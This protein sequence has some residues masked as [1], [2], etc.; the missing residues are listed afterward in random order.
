MGTGSRG[1]GGE[2][3]PREQTGPGEGP[4]GP[5]EGPRPREQAGPGEGPRPGERPRAQPRTQAKGAKEGKGAKGTKGAVRE[6]A[7]VKRSV[8]ERAVV[9]L[10]GGPEGQLLVR[11]A[12]RILAG[13]EGAELHAVHVRTSR[14][15]GGSPAELDRQRAL[16]DRLGG[17]YHSVG[18]TDIAAALADFARGIN[19]TQVVVGVPAHGRLPQLRRGVGARL[20]RLAPG[21]DVH[22]V[23]HGQG[24]ATVAVPRPRSPLG[25]GR[26]IAG[27]VLA[28]LLPVLLQFLL[29]LFEHGHFATDMLVQ[30]SGTIAV[31]LVGGLWPAVLAAVLSSAVVNLSAVHPVGTLGISDPENVLA[32]LIFLAVAIAVSLVVGLSA[33]RSREAD[34]AGAEAAALGELSRSTLAQHYTV[35][36]FMERIREYFQCQGAGLYVL[37]A[38]GGDADNPEEPGSPGNPPGRWR[39]AAAAGKTAA[40]PSGNDIVEPLDPEHTLALSGR[41]FSQ[42]ERHLLTAFGAH[43]LALLQREQLRASQ[44]DIVRLAE[45]NRMR[46]S[47]LRAV[48]HDLRTP[49][50]GIKLAV[51]SLRQDAVQFPPEVEAELLATIEDYTDRLDVLVGNLLDM[52]RLTAD[53]V[54]PLIQPTYWTDAVAAGLRGLPAE[55]VRV[56]LPDNLPPVDA[57]PGMLERVIANVV[58]NA[59]KYAG[60]DV[61][62]TCSATGMGSATVDGSP[63]GELR[64]IDQ[65][66]GIPADQVLSMFRPFQRLD[67]KPAGTGIGLG[68]AVAK[69][70]TDAMGGR[71]AA[72]ETPGGGLTMVIRL[73]LSTGA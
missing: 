11:R 63:A 55:G 4:A 69:G 34:A 19:A 41:P 38:A 47:I 3:G 16:V 7:Q 45:G 33:R 46:T 15:G 8:R 12:V 48:S 58:E 25:R 24:P 27:F 26:L 32:L 9:G 54:T 20:L 22:L 1:T 70:F 42:Q 39:L 71:L 67:D 57:D 61:V 17:S 31:A 59:L 18:G 65:G 62:I 52:S 73:P 43:L 72:E 49:L 21:I 28:V 2:A 37:K 56:D 5:G 35:D 60:P 44:R 68:L 23:S 14:A 53:S 30:L 36:D 50:A 10:S 29:G 6:P 66:R 13:S 64:I 40:E 51:S